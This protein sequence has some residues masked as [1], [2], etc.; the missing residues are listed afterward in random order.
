MKLHEFGTENKPIMVLVHGVLTPWQIWTPQ[1]EAFQNDYHI[2]VVALSGHTEE[3]ASEF[4]S[5]EAETTEI[6]QALSARNVQ[7]IDVLCGL[8]LGGVIAHE[9]WKR[10]TLPIKHLVMDGAPLIPFPLGSGKIMTYNYLSIIHKSKKRD[11][12]VLASFKKNFLPEKYL[13]SYLKIADFMTDTSM[14][15]IVQAANT[16]NLC[17][18]VDNKSKIMFIHGTKGNEILSKKVAKLMK[19]AYPETKVICFKG[20]MHCYKAIYEPEKW[21]E[22]VNAFLHSHT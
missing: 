16:G 18:T 2:F 12:K 17:T 20:D 14:T 6:I 11:P 4:V 5:L 19:K 8:S 3:E 13:D 21:V 22:V 15:N 10:G 9:I 7:A 1:I